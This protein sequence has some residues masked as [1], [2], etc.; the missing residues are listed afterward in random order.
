MPLPA[1]HEVSAPAAWQCIEFISDLHLSPATPRTFDAWSSY[2]HDTEADAVYML[3]DV[4]EAWVGDDGANEPGSFEQRCADVLRSATQRRTIGFMAG[5]RD[6]LVQPGFLAGLGVE[7]LPDPTLLRAFGE[8]LLLTHG[9]LLCLSDSAYQAFRRQVRSPSWQ[10]AF[11]ARPLT[12]R[13]ALARQMREASQASQRNMPPHAWSDV[14]ND[15]AADWLRAAHT[16]VMV[17][18]HTHR[19][20][21]HVLPFGTRHV[22]S[23][24]DFD[25]PAPR[26]DLLRWTRDGLSRQAVP[27]P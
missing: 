18:G 25:V 23:D 8:R 10:Q 5:N 19:P 24:W 9:D 2:L 21:Q 14:D 17:H 3:G 22:L 1:C 20:A 27:A 7:A 16:P 11:L 26:A 4:F 12:E 6:F 15:A 13:R